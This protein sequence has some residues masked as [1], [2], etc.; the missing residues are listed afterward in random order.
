MHLK[1]RGSLSRQ[2][3]YL[4]QHLSSNLLLLMFQINTLALGTF[5]LKQFAG[6]Y[7]DKRCLYY[8]QN[9][10]RMHISH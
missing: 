2:L 7:H 5:C 10:G 8:K 9:S 3:G 6:I 4:K 1:L